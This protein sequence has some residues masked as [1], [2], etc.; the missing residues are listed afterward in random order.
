[1]A[2]GAA[3]CSAGGVVITTLP[4]L[5]PRRANRAPMREMSRTATALARCSSA[6][7]SSPAC[8]RSPMDSSAGATNRRS[9]SEGERSEASAAS[10][11]PQA[12][13][14]S[15]ASSLASSCALVALARA[16]GR[17]RSGARPASSGPG[18]P[19]RPATHRPPG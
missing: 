17:G 2:T 16:A 6:T 13:G 4:R 5:G 10:S 15:P 9:T 19:G 8:H 11:T 3:C 14:S 18:L 7:V 12:P 1:M